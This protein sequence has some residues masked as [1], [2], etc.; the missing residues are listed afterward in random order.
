[1]TTASDTVASRVRT[2]R[3]PRLQRFFR[4]RLAV[5]GAATIAFMTIACIVGPHLVPY[6]D[7]YIDIRNRFAPPL[8]GP[9]ILGTDPLGRDILA[10][11]L[12]AGRI[13]MAVGFAMVSS[14][15]LSSTFVPVLCT[16][17][18]KARAHES[19]AAIGK[20]R[21]VYLRLVSMFVSA[22]WVLVPLYLAGTILAGLAAYGGLEMEIFPR[23]DA[24]RFQLR[25]KAKAGTRVER[26]EELAKRALELVREE[27]GGQVELAKVDIDANPSV[28]SMFQVQSIPA[29]YAMKDGKVVDG[30]LGAQPEWQVAEFVQRLYPSAE[31]REV[32]RL[33]AA[34][35]EA[36]LRAALELEPSEETVI[37]AL[38]ELLVSDGRAEEGLALLERIPE[39]PATRR[40]AALA[41]TGGLADAGDLDARLDSLLSQVKDDD[42][43]RQQFVDLL[44]LI[45]DPD[46]AGAWRR[47][48][49]ARLF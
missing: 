21:G 36:S 24:G 9:H 32:D 45:E 37:V 4:H 33:V 10:R 39:S 26:A 19:E 44:E 28:A 42:D 17:M 48:L 40:V 15:L 22:R 5:F 8:S 2:R 35:D 13:S 27:T 43:A 34:G 41:R 30:F 29:V 1:M 12:M 25:M 38:A 46:A 18:L 23:V 11:L 3:W 20:V 16:W 31:D 7:T 49:A 47:K 14:Y 6:T